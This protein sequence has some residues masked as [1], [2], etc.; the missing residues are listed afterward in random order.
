MINAID[1]GQYIY[2]KKGRVD[3]WRLQRLTYY[4]QA[5]SLAWTGRR[6]IDDDFQ[7]WSDGPVVPR[8]WQ[9]NKYGRDGWDSRELLGAC[10]ENL[11]PEQRAIVDSVLDF[12]GEMPKQEIV[13]RTHREAP[14]RTARGELEP[15]QKCWNSIDVDEMKRFYSVQQFAGTD[16]PV[17]PGRMMEDPGSVASG[18]EQYAAMMRNSVRWSETLELLADR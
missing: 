11:T 17:P 12:Y 15:D 16:V 13:D 5:W 10:P 2:S 8:L 4:A 1:V 18:D 6:L 3:A 9:A 14:W 7:A